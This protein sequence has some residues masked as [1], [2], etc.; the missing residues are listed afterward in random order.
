[1]SI[2]AISRSSS[3]ISGNGRVDAVVFLG[4]H[5]G[6]STTR[7]TTIDSVQH[8]K[9]PQLAIDVDQV[10]GA[11]CG[12]FFEVGPRDG[13]E[14]AHAGDDAELT[15][16]FNSL[17]RGF[18]GLESCHQDGVSLVRA[19][20][21]GRIT[22]HFEK[23]LVRHV[24]I[25][26]V[27]FS[28]ADVFILFRFVDFDVVTDL[29]GA[30][31]IKNVDVLCVFRGADGKPD[32]DIVFFLDSRNDL[33]IF[34]VAASRRGHGPGVD[35]NVSDIPSFHRRADDF[36]NILVALAVKLVP[37]HAQADTAELALTFLV[38]DQFVITVIAPEPAAVVYGDGQ[39]VA[40]YHPDLFHR[41]AAG[42]LFA[43]EA[44]P[45]EGLNILDGYA[46]LLDNAS[47]LVIDGQQKR[48]VLVMIRGI[49]RPRWLG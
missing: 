38:I 47:T 44:G 19:S 37:F 43:V 31:V 16:F 48:R 26:F 30:R 22:Q 20:S 27:K 34:L 13:T 40:G 24:P 10:S 21:S 46:V 4:S 33:G 6:P 39:E 41:V 28:G 23:V 1:M 45:G 9:F 32:P 8:G 2:P 14:Y 7:A 49:V 11:G 36:Q 12:V 42:R 5:K 35:A 17:N 25:H 18:A 29:V 15:Q 3:V